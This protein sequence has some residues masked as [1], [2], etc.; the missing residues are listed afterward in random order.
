MLQIKAFQT[1][2]SG[3][4]EVHLFHADQV[5][6]MQLESDPQ[7]HDGY[8]QALGTVLGSLRWK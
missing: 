2:P 8:R 4:T 7:H 3:I 6:M 5:F 1:V